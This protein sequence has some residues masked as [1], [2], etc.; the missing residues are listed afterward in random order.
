MTDIKLKNGKEIM[1]SNKTS[2]EHKGLVLPGL[3]AHLIFWLF[4]IAG[5]ALDL[6]TKKAVFEW[7]DNRHSYTVID[8]FVQLVRALNDGAAFGLFSGKVLLLTIVPIVALVASVVFFLFGGP[9]P[10]KVYVALGLVAAGACGNLYDRI[11]NGGLVRD[12]ID[13]YYHS[14]HWPTFNVADSLLCIGVVILIL[15][16]IWE[17]FIRKPAQKH[18]QQQK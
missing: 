17:V 14:Y 11:F 18:G 3:K 12:F 4:T 10:R 13:V 15:P 2:Q 5:L 1:D 9:Q 8:G 6:W 7:L 16:M